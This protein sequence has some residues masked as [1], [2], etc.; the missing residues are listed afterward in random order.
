MLLNPTTKLTL[1]STICI[2]LVMFS[3]P[4]MAEE[5]ADIRTSKSIS[6]TKDAEL[7]KAGKDEQFKKTEFDTMEPLDKEGYRAESTVRAVHIGSGGSTDIYVYDAFTELIS[8]FN[9]N[10]FYHRFSVA[11][12]VDTI[13]DTSYVY[14]ELYLSL[15]GGPWNHYA[16][17]QNYHIYRD[18][19]S[20]TFIIETE[21][22]DGFPPGYYDIKIDIYNADTGQWITNYGPYEDASLS[23][24]PLEDSFYDDSYYDG[25]PIE[26]EIVVA[27]HAGSMSWWLLLLPTLII[28]VRRFN[29]N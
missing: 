28:A 20:D 2:T 19:E 17:S 5:T 8:D 25:Y 26:T 9:Y 4:L 1:W 27:G 18:S 6:F 14:A 24:L 29:A 16:S 12:D 22:A 7:D 23:G 11:V 13:Y 10:G 21:L 3:L 15:E